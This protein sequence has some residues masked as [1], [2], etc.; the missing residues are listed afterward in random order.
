MKIDLALARALGIFDE[1]KHPNEVTAQCF[2][3]AASL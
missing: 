3:L 1:R 2:W